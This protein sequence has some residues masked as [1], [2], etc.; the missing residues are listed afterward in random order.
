MASG[1]L[2]LLD[3]IGWILSDTRE[4]ILIDDVYKAVKSH[5]ETN[6][7]KEEF[8]RAVGEAVNLGIAAHRIQ[9]RHNE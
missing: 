4:E 1:N 2:R 5:C 7:P 8:N 6:K 3:E 9:G